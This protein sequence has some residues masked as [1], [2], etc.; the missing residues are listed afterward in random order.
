[1]A[2]T[3]LRDCSRSKFPAWTS[4]IPRR[5]SDGSRAGRRSARCDGARCA[6][7]RSRGAGASAT[8]VARDARVRAS[9]TRAVTRRRG[10]RYGQTSSSNRWYE[11]CV[12]PPQRRSR[13]ERLA[14]RRRFVEERL[15]GR[16][17]TARYVNASPASTSWSRPRPVRPRRLRGVPAGLQRRVASVLANA[18]ATPFSITPSIRHVTGETLAMPDGEPELLRRSRDSDLEVV[19]ATGSTSVHFDGERREGSAHARDDGVEA[20]SPCAKAESVEVPLR[21]ARGVGAMES[22]EP[23]R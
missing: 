7:R 18:K 6:A 20:A 2:S 5:P 14:A 3:R 17:S 12:V 1:M 19:G 23:G 11:F 21:K 13:A 22:S 10:P 15:G 8:A 16:R 9:A 4:P